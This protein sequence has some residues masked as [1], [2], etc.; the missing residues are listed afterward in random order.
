MFIFSLEWK[1][2]GGNTVVPWFS[3]VTSHQDGCGFDAGAWG[4]GNGQKQ[5]YQKK[6]TLSRLMRY[7]YLV[8]ISHLCREDDETRH[9]TPLCDVCWQDV[10]LQRTC[11]YIFFY[12]LDASQNIDYWSPKSFQVPKISMPL[13]INVKK[14]RQVRHRPRWRYGAKKN[15]A[16]SPLI[17]REKK[18]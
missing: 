6:S 13:G 10:G 3:N 9:L 17:N 4:L 11:I 2:P 16:K 18:F 12:Y 8:I 5:K 1:L 15:K 14:G 7:L